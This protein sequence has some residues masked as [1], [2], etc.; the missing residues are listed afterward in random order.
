LIRPRPMS[1][2][3]NCHMAAK[4]ASIFTPKPQVWRK[5]A[6]TQRSRGGRCRAARRRLRTQEA[7]TWGGFVA[8]VPRARAIGATWR[9]TCQKKPQVLRPGVGKGG[10]SMKG[11]K[12]ARGYVSAIGPNE[13]YECRP[14][15]DR[16]SV[17]G[18]R[19]VR[20]WPASASAARAAPPPRSIHC[21]DRRFSPC[22]PGSRSA[23]STW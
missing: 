9:N 16:N 4:V 20:G 2:D 10:P 22:Q 6:Q 15:P 3:L 8:V 5:P 18:A 1:G 7:T 19:A 21:P 14:N 17:P 23:C 12:S 13:G 11:R